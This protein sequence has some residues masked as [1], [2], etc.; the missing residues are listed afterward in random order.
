MCKRKKL[1]FAPPLSILCSTKFCLIT[2][3]LLPCF[4]PSEGRRTSSPAAA[5]IGGWSRTPRRWG[6]ALQHPSCARLRRRRGARHGNP[7]S[8]GFGDGGERRGGSQLGGGDA[9]ELTR[10]VPRRETGRALSSSPRREPRE[11]VELLAVEGAKG[12]RGA[13]SHKGWQG[14]LS[15]RHPNGGIE[16]L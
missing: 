11:G 16:R 2:E 9:P 1:E 6:A 3:L 14:R 4:A 10:A 15:A 13:P 5:R 7:R 12:G 8:V